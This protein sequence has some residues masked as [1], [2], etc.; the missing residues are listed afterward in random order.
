MGTCKHCCD[1]DSQLGVNCIYCG[2]VY[3]LVIKVFQTTNLVNEEFHMSV[4][5]HKFVLVTMYIMEHF[6]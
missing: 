3:A 6:W 1:N 2:V 4:N 5:R